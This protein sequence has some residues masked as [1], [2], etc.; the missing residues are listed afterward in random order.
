MDILFLQCRIID[1]TAV[2]N[3]LSRDLPESHSLLRLARE[4]LRNGGHDEIEAA[5]S[6]MMDL[7]IGNVPETRP[8]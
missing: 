3:I 4:A 8:A 7:A 1:L 5:W 2:A 6:E